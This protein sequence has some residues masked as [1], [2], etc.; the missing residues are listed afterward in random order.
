MSMWYGPAVIVGHA[1]EKGAQ[2][3]GDAMEGEGFNLDWKYK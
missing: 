1:E 3:S 2:H